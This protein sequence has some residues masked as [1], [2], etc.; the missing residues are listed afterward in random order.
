MTRWSDAV[1]DDSGERYQERMAALA[2]SGQ[3]MHGEADFVDGLVIAGTRVLDAGCGAGR[4]AVELAARGFDVVGADVDPS[5]LAVARRSAQDVAWLQRDLAAL[6]PEDPELGGAFDVVLAAGNVI[7]LL[8][9]G[10]EAHVIRRLAGCL[11]DHAPLVAG[12][13]TDVGHLPL[14]DVPVRLEDYD[15]WCAEA[16]LILR[17]RLLTWDRDPFEADQG[18]AVSV[19]ARRA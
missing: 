15:G 19:H 6:D 11:R 8:A 12:F 5:M 7:P 4:V 9:E 10:T 16:G 2:A 3:A 14:D 18:Y 1:G 13:G 17:E